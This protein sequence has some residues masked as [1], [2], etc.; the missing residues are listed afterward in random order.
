M[1]IEAKT[2]D[3]YLKRVP[4]NKKDAFAKLRAVIKANIPEGFEETM[5]YGMIGYVVPHSTYPS[6]YHCDPKLPL[7]F[8][9]IGVQKNFIGLYHNGIYAIPELEEWFR[10]EY[11]KHCKYKLDMGKSCIRLKKNDDIPYELIAELVRKINVD[12]WIDIYGKAIVSGKKK[13]D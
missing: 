12:E 7:P 6:G 4:E 10:Y 8:I 2:I 9:N 11:G 13:A 3:E 1:I 5:S